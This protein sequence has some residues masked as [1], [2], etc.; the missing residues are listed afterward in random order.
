MISRVGC[1]SLSLGDRGFFGR[2]SRRERDVSHSF[3][4]ARAAV[5]VERV[6]AG[7]G[8]A[9]VV[10]LQAVVAGRR[11]V[12][13]DA[14]VRHLSRIRSTGDDVVTFITRHALTC[15]V[16]AVAEDRTEIVFGLKCPVVGPD[17][18]TRRAA[19]DR[20]FRRVTGETIIV[21]RDPAR[22]RLPRP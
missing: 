22:Y 7:E 3:V 16:V 5:D 14:N 1:W 9:T 10:T 6:V 12:L 11:Q 18:V 4:T 2:G 17:R 13:E 15:R 19:A 21:R 8:T 20:R